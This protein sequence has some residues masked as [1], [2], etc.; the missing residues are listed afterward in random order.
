MQILLGARARPWRTTCGAWA[1]VLTRR[2]GGQH[3]KGVIAESASQDF[4]MSKE[5][6]LGISATVRTILGGLE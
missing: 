4:S 5:V 6:G 1:W 3:A 2:R